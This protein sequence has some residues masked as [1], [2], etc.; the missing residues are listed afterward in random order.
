MMAVKIIVMLIKTTV[1]NGSE[2]Y[3]DVDK[4]Y[5]DDGSENYSDVDKDHR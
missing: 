2:N 4:D 3:S 1:I 5:G